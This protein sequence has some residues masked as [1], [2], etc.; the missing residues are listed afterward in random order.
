M[1]LTQ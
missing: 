1:G